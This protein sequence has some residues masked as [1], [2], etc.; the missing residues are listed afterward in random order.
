MSDPES[1]LEAPVLGGLAPGGGEV[2]AERGHG[3][4]PH[5]TRRRLAASAQ[6]QTGAGRPDL[7]HHHHPDRRDGRPVGAA[8]SGRSHLHRQHEGVASDV[9]SSLGGASLRDRHA[10]SGHRLE[11]HIR[12]QGLAAGR[13]GRCG[14]HGLHRLDRRGRS[15][16]LRRAGGTRSSCARQTCSSPFPMY[17]SP[18][19]SSRSWGRVCRTSSLPSGSSAGRASPGCSAVRS[20]A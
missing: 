14:D 12:S 8:L 15:G 13:R 4:G 18:S 17:C 3:R 6:E 10:R 5:A 20:S 19:S 11:D 9:E 2:T 16:L 1:T 7:D